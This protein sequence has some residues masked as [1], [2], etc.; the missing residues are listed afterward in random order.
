MCGSVFSD[1]VWVFFSVRAKSR[2]LSKEN[3]NEKRAKKSP[4]T[5]EIKSVP[6]VFV[7]KK[8]K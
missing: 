2:L 8:T 5:R 4:K 7:A 1:F 3:E 6:F